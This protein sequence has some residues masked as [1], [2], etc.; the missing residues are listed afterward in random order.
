MH[1][2]GNYYKSNQDISN[3]F[4][5]YF[6]DISNDLVN[7]VQST[8]V[9]F[10]S[11]LGPSLI[12]SFYIKPT[13]CHE[14]ESIIMS[15][16]SKGAPIYEIPTKIYKFISKEISSSLSYLINFSI[17]IGEFP[18]ILK[19]ARIIPIFKHGEKSNIKDYRPI[20][21]LPFVSK[22]F[23]KVML[24][25]L[26]NFFSKHN[27]LNS[28][29]YGFREKLNTSDALA[30]FCSYFY[31]SIELEKFSICT[32]I[33]F[34]KAFDTVS[35]NILSTKLEHVGV[36]GTALGWF[37][38]YLNHRQFFIDFNGSFS[39]CRKL[40]V[41]VPQGSV[42]GPFLFLLYINDVVKTSSILK[43]ILYAD[44]TAIL[45]SH[46]NFNELLNVFNREL[47]VFDTWTRANKIVLN[48][49]KTKF[50]VITWRSYNINSTSIEIN[51]TPIEQVRSYDYLG[52][53]IDDKLIFNEHAKYLSTRLSRVLGVLRSLY[54][55][56]KNILKFIY[57][58]LG[59]SVLTYG[60][61]IWGSASNSII[62]P[63]FILQK[64]II[65]V[66]SG[67]AW[68]AHTSPIFKEFNILKLSDIYRYNILIFMYRVLFM[69]HLPFFK[70]RI[71][72]LNVNSNY[73]TRNT[74]IRLPIFTKS[75]T[76]RSLFYVGPH[77]WNIIQKQLK[78]HLS[79]ALFKKYLASN[80][81]SK[82]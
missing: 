1:L 12:N 18:K 20:S 34:K 71:L 24:K 15:F 81:I 8:D 52:V 27:V 62:N 82:Y 61:I 67:N 9:K 41:G 66:V 14:I 19:T 37:R 13:T 70:E 69:N 75:I 80:Y 74:D 68:F 33:D 40:N 32:F 49:E 63:I 5:Q 25:R 53:V 77:Q 50:M 56:P 58:S 45:Y 21:T 78:S 26:C 64:K 39:S 10:E 28:N 43:F 54:F 46:S 6:G 35:H 55:L 2:N 72:S 73:L 79:F 48:L 60:I 59:Y 44:D 57:L 3:A 76:Q 51:D 11:F 4:S 47:K 30:D 31:D 17:R 23:E 65:R 29:Q 22:I 38:S 42:L 16:K 7:S 36:R